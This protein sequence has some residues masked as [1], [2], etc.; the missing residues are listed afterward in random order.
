M[1]FIDY[2]NK[3][4]NFRPDRKQFKTYEKALLWARK[5]FEKFHPDMIKPMKKAA[6]FI[7]ICSLFCSCTICRQAGEGGCY[8]A[9]PKPVYKKN[10]IKM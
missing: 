10:V 8:F 4:K 2:L 6:L 7:A 9:K 3:A 1:Y 5:N